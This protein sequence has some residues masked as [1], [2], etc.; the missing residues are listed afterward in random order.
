MKPTFDQIRKLKEETGAP[1]IRVKKVLEE[2]KGDTKEAFRILQKEGFEKAAS[3]EGRETNAG[4]VETYIHATKSS[5]ATVV[6][7]SET[8]FVSRTPE[9]GNLAHEIAMQTCAMN[10]KSKEELL[11]QPYIRDESKTIGQLIKEHISRFGENIVLVD[12]KRF[13]V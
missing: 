8:D 3:K 7:A 4:V 9:F 11:A 10:P 12:F 2:V 5:G 13:E 1:I 6:L